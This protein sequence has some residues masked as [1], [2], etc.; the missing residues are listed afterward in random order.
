[1]VSFL[2]KLS[3]HKLV[4]QGQWT[5]FAIEPLHQW[6]ANQWSH[7]E[8]GSMGRLSTLRFGHQWKPHWTLQVLSS[9]QQP[10]CQ[11]KALK[12][13][14]LQPPFQE[15]SI[16]Y[17]EVVLLEFKLPLMISPSV[18]SNRLSCH[19]GGER[20]AMPAQ[21]KLDLYVASPLRFCLPHS[22]NE[23]IEL[24]TFLPPR[25]DGHCKEHPEVEKGT[26]IF[27]SVLF[28]FALLFKVSEGFACCSG[29]SGCRCHRTPPWSL[30]LT[31]Q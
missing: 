17:W 21:K 18:S 26:N 31:P 5:S 10:K 3:H 11:C 20:G 23:S 27:I 2:S 25:I 24:I 22:G 7:I 12:L 28:F 19:I 14:G 4:I 29:S 15:S 9:I 6:A 8:D 30:D 1:M 13:K 16:N